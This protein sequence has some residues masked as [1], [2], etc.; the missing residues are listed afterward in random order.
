MTIAALFN[1][2]TDPQAMLR[3][4]FHNN[5]SHLLAVDA[6]RAN[7]GVVL[8]TYVIDPIPEN[9]FPGWLYTHQ[10]M[11]NSVNTALGLD[12]ADLSDMDPTKL[13]QLTY[14]IQLHA[15]EHRAWG[16]TL[17]FG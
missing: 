6:I 9:D 8:P 17:G 14:W 11:H 7:T 15:Q 5:D 1:I 16:D 13:D 2:P 3:F 10:S 4:S 12:G